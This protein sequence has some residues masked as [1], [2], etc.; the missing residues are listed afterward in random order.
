MSASA[1]CFSSRP[2][3]GPC[4]ARAASSRRYVFDLH[5]EAERILVKPANAGVGRGPAVGIFAQARNCSV[6][7]HFSL[8]VAPAAINHLADRD[9][10]D[11]AGDHAVHELR[12]VFAGDAIFVERR[13]VNQGAGIADCVVLVVVV[14]LVDADGVIPGPLAIVHAFA[15][16]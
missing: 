5:V 7:N 6:I 8:L 10:V 9:F 13:D 4:S 15:K 11:V 14:H 2:E 3:V 1:T 16:L 12:R